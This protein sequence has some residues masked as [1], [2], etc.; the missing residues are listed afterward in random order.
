MNSIQDG[1]GRITCHDKF[2]YTLGKKP[3]LNDSHAI[4][5]F[6]GRSS[7]I[8]GESLIAKVDYVNVWPVRSQ[9]LIEAESTYSPIAYP[10]LHLKYFN[11]Y[12]LETFLEQLLRSRKTTSE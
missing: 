4:G 7:S 9:R 5:K 6:E 8:W 10:D 1:T 3:L 11:E 12:S 2:R